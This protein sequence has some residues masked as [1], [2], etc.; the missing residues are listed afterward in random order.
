MIILRR[1]MT[2][3]QQRTGRKGRKEKYRRQEGQRRKG[4]RRASLRTSPELHTFRL[5]DEQRLPGEGMGKVMPSLLSRTHSN[6]AQ[7][8]TLLILRP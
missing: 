6:S 7:V 4:R 1:H 8:P 3:T 2:Q 5:E